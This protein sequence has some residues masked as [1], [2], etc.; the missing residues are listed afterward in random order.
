LGKDPRD[1]GVL[2]SKEWDLKDPEVGKKKDAWAMQFMERLLL[3]G[4]SKDSPISPDHIVSRFLNHAETTTQ[5]SRDFMRDFPGKRLP[6][7]FK[8]YPGKMDH[9]TCVAFTV[10]PFVEVDQRKK[11]F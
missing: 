3:E 11:T 7:D 9:A 5:S 4:L 1:V 8:T 6:H 2:D 10:G